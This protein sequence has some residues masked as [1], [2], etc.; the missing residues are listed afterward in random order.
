MARTRRRAVRR[1]K[2]QPKKEI[3]FFEGLKKFLAMF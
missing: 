3:G 1:M 2:K